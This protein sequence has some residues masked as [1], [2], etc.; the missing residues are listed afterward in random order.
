MPALAEFD[1]LVKRY[2]YTSGYNSTY[3]PW[4]LVFAI[5]VP[6]I[7][8]ILLIVARRA[9]LRR[10]KQGTS[11]IPYTGW[12]TFQPG[13]QHQAY[14]QQQQYQQQPYQ[15]YNQQNTTGWYN[16]NSN[17]VKPEEEVANAPPPAY[18]RPS[19]APPGQSTNNVSN[20]STYQIPE[21]PPPGQINY[22][23]YPSETYKRT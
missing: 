4:W 2:Y 23:S 3:R 21:G 18:E 22:P 7:L 13:Q 8:I 10:R 16:Y 12:T 19:G 11:P 15:G 6:I 20:D 17:Y 5:G 14:P 1:D 9:N